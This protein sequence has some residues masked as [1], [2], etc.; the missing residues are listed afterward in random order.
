VVGRNALG[1]CSYSVGDMRVA[2]LGSGLSA[3]P[4]SLFC[5]GFCWRTS[6]VPLITWGGDICPVTVSPWGTMTL[7]FGSSPCDDGLSGALSLCRFLDRWHFMISW[8][9]LMLAVRLLGLY[10]QPSFLWR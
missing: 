6:Y 7:S 10:Q 8:I 9:L 4:T 2:V 3:C 5:C 1:D